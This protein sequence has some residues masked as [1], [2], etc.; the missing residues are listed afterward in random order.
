MSARHR[1]AFLAVP[2]LVLATLLAAG[3]SGSEKPVDKAA[4]E[5]PQPEPETT[6][7]TVAPTTTTL[8]PTYPLTG[9]PADDAG[10][11]GRAAVAVKIDNVAEARPQAGIAAADVVY[12]EFTEGVTRFIAVYHSTDAEVLG[13][14]RSVR[15]ADPVIVTPLGGVFGFSGGSPGAEALARQAPLTNVT[16]NDTAVMYRRSGRAAPHNLYTSTAGLYSRAP[17]DAGSPRPLAQFLRDGQSFTGP[18]A[19]AVATLRVVAA[20]MVVVDYEWDAAERKW[21]RTTDGRAHL[22]EEGRIAPTTVIVQFTPYEYFVDDY[23][24]TYPLVEG[25]GEA[26][27]FAAGSLVSGTWSKASADAVTTFT[28]SGGAPIVLPPGQTWVH[29]VAPGSSVTTG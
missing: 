11:A 17:S 9:R 10:R 24:V 4:A 27:V 13:P 6:T 12:E 26:W 23:S 25:T 1:P 29:L 18:G 7:T 14:V 2:L 8:P 3:C 22:V 16:E 21:L 20:P 19:M 15:P 5:Q 28:D